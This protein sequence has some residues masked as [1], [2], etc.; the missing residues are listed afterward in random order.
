MI[1]MCFP[2][3]GIFLFCFS[4]SCSLFHF[5]LFSCSPPFVP[6]SFSIFFICLVDVEAKEAEKKGRKWKKGKK[7]RNNNSNNA[8]QTTLK[9][10]TTKQSTTTTK[11]H[12]TKQQ[13]PNK[14]KEKTGQHK[15]KT[16]KKK[17]TKLP[18]NCSRLKNRAENCAH[19]K[20][21]WNYKTGIPED[22]NTKFGKMQEEGVFIQIFSNWYMRKTLGTM[23]PLKNLCL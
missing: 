13:Q 12:Q 19:P 4:G 20:T 17:V 7:N 9:Q 3:L 5:F 8:Q 11:Q 23:W 1:C 22:K 10:I 14:N 15:N 6:S 21:L 2:F 16:H 18:P